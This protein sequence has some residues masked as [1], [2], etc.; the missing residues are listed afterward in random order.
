MPKT[1]NC[2]RRPTK[3]LYVP[4]PIYRMRIKKSLRKINAEL[5][6][7]T[8]QF[9]Q[10][11]LAETNAYELVVDNEAD[12][13]GLPEALKAAAADVAKAKGHDGKWVFTLQNPSLMP[14]LQYAENRELRRQM[15]DAYQMRGNN[16][17]ANDNKETLL[18][19]ANLRLEKAKLL[20]YPSHAAYVLEEAM[21]LNPNNV[22][23]LLNKLWT[24][25]LAKAKIE[26]ADIQKEIDAEGGDFSV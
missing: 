26:A 25:A 13:E 12:L 14:F 2:S 18:K 23:D 8:T 22:Y 19:T 9:G 21:A 16:G 24:P 3:V 1:A 7:L 17:N 15:W 4:V 20:G 5:S 6:V 11:L 10:N